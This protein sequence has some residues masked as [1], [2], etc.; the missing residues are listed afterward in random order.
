MPH[1]SRSGNGGFQ[2]LRPRRL[3]FDG[4]DDIYDPNFPSVLESGLSRA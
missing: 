1:Q 4:F 3:K 2:I